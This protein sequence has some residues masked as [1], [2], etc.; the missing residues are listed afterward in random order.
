MS[1][2]A[3]WLELG[4]DRVF[5]DVGSAAEGYWRG[6]GYVEPGSIAPDQP[7][8]PVEKPAKKVRVK[9][10]VEGSDA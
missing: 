7:E 6:V 5:V 2:N 4:V 1:K 8:A 9:K 10:V 3:V